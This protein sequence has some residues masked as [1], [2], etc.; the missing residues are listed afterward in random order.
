MPLIFLNLFIAI[1]LQ[2]FDQM[3]QKEMLSVK[4]EELE[5]FRNVWAIYDPNVRKCLTLAGNRIYFIH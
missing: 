1:I 5:H 4:E 2:G 3:N